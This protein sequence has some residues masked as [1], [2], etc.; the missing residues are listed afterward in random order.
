MDG[1]EDDAWSAVA[2]EWA[3]LWGD[4]ADPVRR[5]IS[6]ATGIRPG[7]RV[8][9]VG[10]GSGEFL[11]ALAET[12]AE[13]SGIDPAA[14]MVELS[15]SRV[16]EADVRRGAVESLP[17]PDASFDV[18]VAINALQFADDPDAALAEMTRVTVAGGF[19]AVANWADA[20]C[21]DIHVLEQAVAASF[22]EELPPDDELR[23]PG[24]LAGFFRRG[25]LTPVVT[26]LIDAPWDAA[27][28][29]ALVRGI[30]LG[31][32]EEGLSGGAETVLAAAAPFRL[33]SGSYRLNNALRF[34]VGTTA[35]SVG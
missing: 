3:R 16:P 2:A 23:L 7:T 33:D 31:E 26:G 6:E 24:G 19:V 32:D 30:L 13:C 22:E 34:A 11:R 12:G 10:C 29:D 18:V 20:P 14:A 15:R 9:D 17:W 5:A 1:A 4:F 28:D 25:G 35:P 27:D 21:N 8:L